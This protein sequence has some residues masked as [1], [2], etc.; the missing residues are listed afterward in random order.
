MKIVEV[1]T[2]DELMTRGGLSSNLD[3]MQWKGQDMA[4]DQVIPRTESGSDHAL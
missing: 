4:A 1:G 3:T 2:R